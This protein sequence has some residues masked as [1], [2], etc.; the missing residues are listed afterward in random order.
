MLSKYKVFL[1][2]YGNFNVT[3]DVVTGYFSG[4]L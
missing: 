2:I 1:P 3:G 4:D